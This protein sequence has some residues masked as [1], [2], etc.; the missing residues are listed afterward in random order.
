VG[1]ARIHAKLLLPVRCDSAV[2]GLVDFHGYSAASGDWSSY[3]S[4][5]AEGYAVAA[6]DCRGQGGK[7]QDNQ[8]V[9]GTTL[10]GHIVRGLEDPDPR[11]LYYRSVYLDTVRLARVL[12]GLPEVD[13]ARIG[14]MGASQG[15]GLALACAALEPRVAK[16]VAMYPFLCDFKRV[17]A[18]DMAKDAYE[19]LRLFFR[20]RDPQHLREDEFFERLGYID[21]QHLAPRIKADVLMMSGLMDTICPPSTQFSAFNKIR[22]P[23]RYELFPD[24]GHEHPPTSMDLRFKQLGTPWNV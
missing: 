22:S 17:W 16:V 5:V 10:R 1:G 7:S 19:E 15:G 8:S 6:M 3:L 18:M 23:K 14:A 24:F 4:Y 21:V 12:M 9:E 13:A 20:W 2:P 11:R